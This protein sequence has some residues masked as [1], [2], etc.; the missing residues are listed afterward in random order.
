M[1]CFAAGAGAGRLANPGQTS[2]SDSE[3]SLATETTLTGARRQA[4][5]A[6]G[7]WRDEERE[8]ARY[9]FPERVEVVAEFPMTPSGK[10]QKYR[11]REIVAARM[12]RP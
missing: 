10:I 2:M 7:H 8:L 1:I 11:R 6:D 4:A 3:R 12:E 9:K 5:R